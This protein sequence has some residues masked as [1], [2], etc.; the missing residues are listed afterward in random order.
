MSL[1]KEK[2]KNI[3][4]YFNLKQLGLVAVSGI[5]A[6]KFLQGQI[7]CDIREV[8]ETQSRLGAWCNPKGRVQALFRLYQQQDVYY[9]QLPHSLIAQTIAGLHKYAV[10]FK[11]QMEN[12]SSQYAQIGMMGDLAEQQLAHTFNS[13][14]ADVDQTAINTDTLILRVPGLSLRFIIVCKQEHAP[15]L[16]NK[17]GVQ[18]SDDSN[19]WK[20]A[21]IMAGI[22]AIYP[23]T[24]AEFTPQQLNLTQINGV[25]FKK[26]CYTGQEIIART[27]HLGKPK[28]QMYRI[29]FEC[30]Q[31]FPPNT[32]LYLAKNTTS[33]AVGALLESAIE[34]GTCYQ[35]LAVMQ[36]NIISEQV[37]VGNPTGSILTVL[38][39]PYTVSL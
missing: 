33:T 7:T 13:L 35:A 31:N 38:N 19:A 20:L 23:E 9:L 16:L 26:G 30:P 3:P 37:T 21:D 2:P 10:F 14:P 22:P 8:T 1:I 29:Q 15:S 28:Q 12:V 11:V 18:A 17:L 27:H 34:Q 6:A 24:Y 4:A 39:L 25:S 36:N 32:K 5:D